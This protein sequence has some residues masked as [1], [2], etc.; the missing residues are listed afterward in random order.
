MKKKDIL[1]ILAIVT[2]GVTLNALKVDAQYVNLSVEKVEYYKKLSYTDWKNAQEKQVK[3]IQI[4]IN[5]MT[6]ERFE[7][8]KEMQ[9][10]Y[11]KNHF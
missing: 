8:M 7:K 10:N 6:E 9:L 4:K 11:W 2:L 1:I 5:N 3:K